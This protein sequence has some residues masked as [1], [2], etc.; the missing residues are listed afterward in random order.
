MIKKKTEMI[1]KMSVIIA[2]DYN[3]ILRIH[4]IM[5]VIAW[6][7]SAVISVYIARYFRRL[8]WFPA[9]LFFTITTLLLTIASF[10]LI[11]LHR[12]Y[13][14]FSSFYSLNNAHVKIGLTVVIALILQVI[15][16]SVAHTLYKP[17][18]YLPWFNQIHRVLGKLLAILAMINVI[19]GM[20]V[21]S[22]FGEIST[23]YF[24]AVYVLLGVIV[25]TFIISEIVHHIT[26]S[27]N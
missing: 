8:H 27:R 2:Q 9:H 15:L 25:I 23:G 7:G 22:S 1:I 24:I 10:I 20:Y 12:P 26:R 4:G 17:R 21:Y 16:G 13:P 6:F 5:M 19:I 18:D 11:V 3:Y 14:H